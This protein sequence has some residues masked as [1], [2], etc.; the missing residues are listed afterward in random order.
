MI[1]TFAAID[2][3][4]YGIGMKIFEIS[5]KGMKEIDYVRHRIELG[6][7]IYQWGKLSFEKMDELCDVLGRFTEI[8]KTYRTDSYRAYGTSA[9][10]E[11]ENT[12]II[13]EQMKIKTGLLLEVLSNAEQRYLIYKSVASKGEAFTHFIEKGTAIVDVG[14]GSIQVSLFDKDKL[15]ATQNMRIGILRIREMLRNL[16]PKS[17]H[18]ERLIEEL[19]DHELHMFKKLYL[20]D[21]N[22]KNIIVIDDYISYIM[23]KLSEGFSLDTITSEQY[24]KFLNILREKSPEQVAKDMGIPEENSSLLV[25]SAICYKRMIEVMDAET[26]WAP[27]VTL[28]DGMAYDYAEKNKIFKVP[29]NFENDIIA[30]AKNISKRYM[31]S[32]ST[33]TALETTALSIFDS[34]KKVHGLGKRER[35]LLQI[36]SLLHDCGKYISFTDVEVCSY[37]IIMST[38]IIGLSQKEREIIANVVKYNVQYFLSFSELSIGSMMDERDYIVIAKLAAILRVANGLDRG[39]K[40]KFKKLKASVKEKQLVLSLDSEMDFT[41]EKGLFQEKVNF[42]EEVFSLKPVIKQKRIYGSS[43]N[44]ERV[45]DEGRDEF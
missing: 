16:Q 6:S 44:V 37:N 34:M 39:H 28:S 36:A 9:I 43:I 33:G 5:K 35:L 27:G 20:K 13:Q 30:C 18:Y 21:C 40:Q 32:K 22:I 3:G 42:F 10:R 23:G 41:L 1:K 24:M 12:L 8:M 7:D 2:V 45:E 38:E 29:H 19:V 25:P 31:G 11:A 26:L 4:S 14:G 17:S 15:F